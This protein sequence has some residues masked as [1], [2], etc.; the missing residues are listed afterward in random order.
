MAK[1]TIKKFASPD[2]RRPFVDRGHVD[3]LELGDGTCGKAVFEP[4][5]KWS[6]H[7]RP[8]AGTSSCQAEHSGYVVSGRMHLVMDD[9]QEADMEA[10]DCFYIPPGHDAWT[11]GNDACVCLDFTGMDQYARP[12]AERRTGAGAEPQQPGM[13]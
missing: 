2:Q 8:I 9:G 4:G 3:I 7:V 12:A 6:K 10:G 13:H 5:W 1:L 11:V